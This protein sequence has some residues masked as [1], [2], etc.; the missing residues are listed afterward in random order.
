MDLDRWKYIISG[1]GRGGAAERFA[2]L[3]IHYLFLKG[4]R[5][6]KTMKREGR[7][8]EPNW[9]ILKQINRFETDKNDVQ[10]KQRHF[11]KIKK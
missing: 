9:Q 5:Y 10:I 4:V 7:R 6:W 2:S 11:L 1:R 8:E 3:Y